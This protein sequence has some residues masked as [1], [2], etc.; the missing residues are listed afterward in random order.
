MWDVKLRVEGPEKQFVNAVAMTRFQG[1]GEPAMRHSKRRAHVSVPARRQ[2]EGRL[3]D[4]PAPNR[5][6]AHARLQSRADSHPSRALR[7]HLLPRREQG[8]LGR[9]W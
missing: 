7:Q 5:F 3:V 4:L 6:G 9:L 8:Q 1:E 2:S